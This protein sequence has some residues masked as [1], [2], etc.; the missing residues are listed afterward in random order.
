[1][2]KEAR[3]TGGMEASARAD[4]GGGVTHLCGRREVA[5]APTGS[6]P[7]S[8]PLPRSNFRNKGV[9]GVRGSRFRSDTEVRGSRLDCTGGLSVRAGRGIEPR[10]QA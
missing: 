3:R 5:G 9:P 2:G 10:F 8:T 6:R 7:S 1:M 4:E